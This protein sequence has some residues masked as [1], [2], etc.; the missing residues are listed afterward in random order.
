ML[1][2]GLR[3]TACLSLALLAVVFSQVHADTITDIQARGVLR[4]GV[5]GD[6]RPFSFCTNEITRC[7]GFDVDVARRIAADL[8]I[9]L[10]TVRFRWPEVL[11][12][13]N[14]RAFDIAMSGITIRPERV[15]HATFTQPYVTAAAMVLV[16]DAARFPSL[17]AVDQSQV[18]VAVNAGGHLEQVARGRLLSATI[19]PTAKNLSL[20]TLVLH[21]QADALVTDS[22]EAVHF[23]AAYPSLSALP[24][25]GR[26]R[27]A[28]MLRRSDSDIRTWLDHWLGEREADGFLASLRTQWFGTALPIAQHPLTSLFTLIDTRLA[29]MPAV[30]DY[31]RRHQL[32]I[33]DTQQE[34]AVLAQVTTHARA[35]GVDEQAVRD[36]FRVQIELAKHVQ[37]AALQ[38][39]AADNPLPLWARGRDLTSDLRPALAELNNRIVSEL[40]HV[41][42]F[43]SNETTMKRTVNEELTTRGI[44]P[45]GKYQLAEALL[46]VGRNPQQKTTSKELQNI[47]KDR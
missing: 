30:A 45:A 47:T 21:G 40:A 41:R 36:V 19:S 20:P 39:T 42:H 33:E 2:H 4:V 43:L 32:P 46:K 26:D 44:D 13:L 34:Q 6:Y 5:S 38:N 22:L 12:D 25:F 29:L 16:A 11:T 24:A 31:K 18:R 15:L 28:Y 3:W 35:L 14:A 37:Q 8:G 9:T 10:T 1:Q 27:K 17:A 23:L 7:E